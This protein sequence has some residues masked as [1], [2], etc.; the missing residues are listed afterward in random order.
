MGIRNPNQKRARAVA[1]LE[2]RIMHG[3]TNEEIAKS[4]NVAP[5]TVARAMS[6]AAKG[7]IIIS[8]EDKLHKELLPKAHEALSTL[9]DEGSDMVKAKVALKIYEGAN[10]IKRT[11][12]ITPT[13]Q[14]DADD[15][16]AY[17]FSKRTQALLEETS[18]D[19]TPALTTLEHAEPTAAAAAHAPRDSARD[20]S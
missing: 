10:I 7:D 4:F 19:V 6:L 15:L 12:T 5:S 11:Q 17:I 2:Q 16:S 13:E 9:L 20:A 3:K 18:I 1:M 8:F 14:Q